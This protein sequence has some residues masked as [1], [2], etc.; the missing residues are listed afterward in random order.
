MLL[1]SKGPFARQATIELYNH[2]VS[3]TQR[4]VSVVRLTGSLHSFALASRFAAASIIT[5]T[6]QELMG[7]KSALAA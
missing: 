2:P 3:Y 1:Q 4:G 7:K 6:T 5:K